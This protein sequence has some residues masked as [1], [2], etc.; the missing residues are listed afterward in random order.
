MKQKLIETLQTFGYPVH[1]Q[2]TLNPDEAYPDTFIT[3]W[4]DD[5]DDTVHFDNKTQSTDWFFNVIIYSNNPVI[6]NEKP[7]E[8]RAKLKAAGFIPQGKG[9]DIPS[10][11]ET[12]TGWT[13][14]YIYTEYQQF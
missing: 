14:D 11:K 4:T 9:H 2:G 3:F 6:V 1:L 5:T 12:H 10:D 13:M 7:K 8:I